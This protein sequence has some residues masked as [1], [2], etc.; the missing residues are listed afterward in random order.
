M[1]FT[2]YTYVAFLLAAFVLH[3]LLPDRSR[4]WLLIILSYVFY[5]SWKWPYGFLLLG[6]SLLTFGFGAALG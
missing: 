3:W 1:I 6:V 4:K 5:C 2:S